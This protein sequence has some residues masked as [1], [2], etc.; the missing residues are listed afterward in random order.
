MEEPDPIKKIN[1]K[2]AEIKTFAV[3]FSLDRIIENISIATNTPSKP[4]Q[5]EIIIQAFQFHSEGNI[6]EASKY[7]QY[8]IDKEVKDHRVFSNY[9][10]LLKDIGKSKEAILQLRKAIKLHPHYGTAHLNLGL[11]LKNIGNLQEA[12]LST[13]KAIQLNP[14]FAEAHLNLGTILSELGNLKEAE[15]SIRRA[16]Q[17]NPDFAEAHL[18]LGTIS[19]DLGNLREAES[20]ILKAIKLDPENKKNKKHLINLLTVYKPIKSSSHFLYWINEE[21]RKVNL[22]Y[23]D[24]NII[25]DEKAIKIY[26]DGLKI[27]RGYNLDLETSLSQIY[28]KN[29][30]NLNCKRHKL[31]FKHNKI[32]PKFCFGCYKVQVE[33]NSIIELI[34]LFLVFNSLEL[35]NNN[36]RKCLIELRPNISGFYKGLIYCLSLKE[37]LE[38]SNQINIKI[39]NNISIDLISKVKRGCSEYPLKFPQYKEINISGD[40]PMNYNEKWSSIEKEIDKGNKD[41]GQEIKSIEGFNL[42]D[43]LIMRNWIAYAQRIGDQQ[44]HKITN[45]QIKA[46]KNFNYLNKNFH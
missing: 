4:T 19:R 13:R 2:D 38:I 9:G 16:I 34:K 35:Q 44:V 1:T 14:D 28:K 43:F 8:L 42:N 45:E 3:P 15:L 39:Q 24:K 7:Y 40:Q 10:V 26:R 6:K 12:E 5:E 22:D 41:W 30:I 25:I 37:A 20:S 11:I 31:I 36:T 17:L 32:I 21:F 29:D 46:S 23:D 18:N 27:Y 33:L